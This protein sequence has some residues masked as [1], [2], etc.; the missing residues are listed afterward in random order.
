MIK[1]SQKTVLLQEYLTDL[2]R[3]ENLFYNLRDLLSSKCFLSGER[4]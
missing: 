4:G 3:P 2:F 1:G